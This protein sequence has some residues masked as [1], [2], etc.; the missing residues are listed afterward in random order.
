M[1]IDYK[2]VKSCATLSHAHTQTHFV[3]VIIQS[4]PTITLYNESNKGNLYTVYMFV[5][6]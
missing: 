4:S 6:V 5:I 3:S 2:D 1:W